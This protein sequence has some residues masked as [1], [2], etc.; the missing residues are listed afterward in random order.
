MSPSLAGRL[1]N[2]RPPNKSPK[3]FLITVVQY[4]FYKGAKEFSRERTIFPTNSAGT[5][6][7]PCVKK[8]KK[9]L[10]SIPSNIYKNYS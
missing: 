9:E 10:S 3:D 1:P 8:E 2:T 5:I 7:S 6:G 4:M